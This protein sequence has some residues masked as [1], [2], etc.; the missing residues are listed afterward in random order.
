MI[1][2]CQESITRELIV[3]PA[4]FIF[5]AIVWMYLKYRGK[6]PRLLI[7]ELPAE[8]PSQ[9][10]T[11]LSDED[12]EKANFFWDFMNAFAFDFERAG[13]PVQY[14]QFVDLL[15]YAPS[16][17]LRIFACKNLGSSKHLRK[18]TLDKVLRDE[19]IEIVLKNVTSE[20]NVT[21]NY[22]KLLL[23]LPLKSDEIDDI[24]N[25]MRKTPVKSDVTENY[26]TK[27]RTLR[28]TL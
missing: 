14:R 21:N 20:I 15:K 12:R 2:I 10:V 19:I 8:I 16:A 22:I 17:S 27:L 5:I 3:L 1:Y 11:D 26:I 23:Q 28:T 13:H 25:K 18:Y 6:Q 4:A 7:P 24:I 9:D